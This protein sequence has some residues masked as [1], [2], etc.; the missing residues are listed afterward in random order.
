ML[1]TMRNDDH[2][3]SI[4]ACPRQCLLESR[5]ILRHN[6]HLCHVVKLWREYEDVPRCQ[7][8]EEYA[9]YAKDV[10]LIGVTLGHRHS[11]WAK[12]CLHTE[13][14]HKPRGSESGRPTIS[15]TH[16]ASHIHTEYDEPQSHRTSFSS[17]RR[18][19]SK[20][21][22][23]EM[24]KSFRNVSSRV[25]TRQDTFGSNISWH[26]LSPRQHHHEEHSSQAWNIPGHRSLF[27]CGTWITLTWRPFTRLLPRCLMP[28]KMMNTA[29]TRIK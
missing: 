13:T 21:E 22:S 3:R 9:E 5:P 6:G 4:L 18:A 17:H 28:P 19:F 23:R 16:Q 11:F 8:T 2:L 14:I 7:D 27:F 26:K 15:G 24:I 1:W 25:L 12:F 20:A 10:M 29:K